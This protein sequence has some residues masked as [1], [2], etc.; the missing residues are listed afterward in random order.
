MAKVD[1]AK[2]PYNLDAE[3]VKWVEDTIANLTIDEKIGQLFFNMGTSTEPEYL[4][5]V[6]D[7]Y[8]ISGVRYNKSNA[9]IVANGIIETSKLALKEGIRVGLGT[10]ASCPFAFQYGMWR[11][12]AY[13]KKYVGVT[14]SFAVKTATLINAQILGKEKEIGSLD[15]GKYFDAVEI[16]RAHV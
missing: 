16:G 9:D 13:F 7:T 5:D 2:Q 14:A 1:L 8:H 10:D 4:K 15:K 11:E 3:G 12:L 6:L